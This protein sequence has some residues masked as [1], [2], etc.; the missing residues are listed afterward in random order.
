MEAKGDTGHISF[1]GTYVTITR[2]GFRARHTLGEGSKRIHVSEISA[3]RFKRGGLLKAGYVQI[4][5][6]GA[7][8]PFSPPPTAFDEDAVIYANQSSAPFESLA[9]AVEAAVAQYQVAQV[10]PQV[11]SAPSAA[12]GLL[13]ADELV[14]LSGLLQQGLLTREEFDRPKARLLGG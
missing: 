10:A 1:D 2:E 3:V 7:E 12:P 14:K 9:A 13:V 6:K 11:S 8:Q 5:R 4:V